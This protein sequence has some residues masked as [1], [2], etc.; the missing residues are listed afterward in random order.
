MNIKVATL[1]SV[2]KNDDPK[3]FA[4]ALD[5]IVDQEL[6]AGIVSHIYLAVDGL[7]TTELQS[8]VDMYSSRLHKVCVSER[9]Q[10]LARALNSLI[11]ELEDEMYVFRMDSDD[12]S[13]PNRFALQIDYMNKNPEVGILGTGICEID[14][15]TGVRRR[16]SYLRDSENLRN[17]LCFGTPV[18]HPTVCFRRSVVDF[19]RSYPTT[20]TNEDIALWFKCAKA[21]VVFRN[22][23]IPLL[24]F[25]INKG[26]WK[27]RSYKKAFSE[28][29]CYVSGIWSIHRITWRYIFPLSRLALRLAPGS[30]SKFFYA[31]SIRRV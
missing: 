9:N 29:M 22:L 12:F 27:R 18:A 30:I 15:Q 19:F 24:E 7:L 10:G 20:G 5:S 6:P 28:F 2:Y 4:R 26:F 17:Y 21:G 8:V 11:A 16:V 23:D 25:T 13:L 31:S 1:I 3:L 14:T